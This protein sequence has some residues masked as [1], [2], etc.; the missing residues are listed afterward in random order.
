MT[1]NSCALSAVHLRK[2]YAGH[3]AVAD[4]SFSVRRGELFGLLGPN[5]AGKTT[6]IRMVLGILLPDSGTVELFGKPRTPDLVRRVGY[7]PEERGLYRKM[8]V[9]DHLVFLGELH[10]LR[11]SEAKRRAEGWLERLELQKWARVKVEALSKGMQQKVQLVGALLYEPELLILDEPFSGLDPLNQAFFREV[12]TELRSQGKALVF[13]THVL[14]HA[15]K[16]CDSICL[17]A[18]GKVVLSGALSDIRR[19]F[20]QPAYEAEFSGAVP[21]LESLPGIERIERRAESRIRL[22]PKP[23]VDVPSL[24]RE[25]SQR[26]ALTGFQS[27]EPDLETIYLQAVNRAS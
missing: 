19:E 2:A 13:S 8:T 3:L 21:S 18:Q 20:A 7:L 17:I 5:G 23:Q 24:V 25:L 22:Y 27:L 11:R 14:E 4:V 10:G 12:F 1:E 15:E 16:L 26:G 6:T 9:L